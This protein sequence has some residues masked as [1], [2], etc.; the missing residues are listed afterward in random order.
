M[1]HE[2][3]LLQRHS[4]N[5][6]HTRERFPIDPRVARGT[7]QIAPWISGVVRLTHP[8][9]PG[10][11]LFHDPQ[12]RVIAAPAV[13]GNIFVTVPPNEAWLVKCI[14]F[15]FTTDAT[16]ANRQ[17]HLIF[18]DNVETFFNAIPP[19]TQ[20]ASL[21]FDYSWGRNFPNHQAIGLRMVTPIPDV[22]LVT[23]WRVSTQVVDLQA[24]DQFSLMALMVDV[25]PR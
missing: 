14:R 12:V 9:F 10:S 19:L 2:E 20:A 24:G 17:V 1:P 23:G 8:A 22:V 21:T 15:T 3:T 11:A 16:A 6:R 18:D 7:G 5:L 25:F 4:A 13:G